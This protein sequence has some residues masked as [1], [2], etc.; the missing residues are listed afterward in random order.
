LA[1]KII[2]RDVVRCGAGSLVCADDITLRQAC[3]PKRRGSHDKTMV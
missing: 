1:R 2:D 3:L